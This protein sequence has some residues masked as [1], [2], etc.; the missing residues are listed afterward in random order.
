MQ[1]FLEEWYLKNSISNLQHFRHLQDF[2]CSI[3]NVCG[4]FPGRDE[5]L[6][7]IKCSWPFRNEN[8]S[9]LFGWYPNWAS[10]PNQF[11][12]YRIYPKSLLFEP[13]WRRFLLSIKKYPFDSSMLIQGYPGHRQSWLVFLFHNSA[14]EPSVRIWKSHSNK[15]LENSRTCEQADEQH[16]VR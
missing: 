4:G 2:P 13:L 9:C 8:L 10:T 6:M 14:Q 12:E 5:H 7:L 15:L 11:S 1:H 3:D 16:D